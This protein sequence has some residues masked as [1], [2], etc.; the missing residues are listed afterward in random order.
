MHYFIVNMA[1]SDLMISVVHLPWRIS[2]TYRDG[3]WLVDGI[4]GTVLSKLVFFAWPV[5]DGVSIVSMIVIAVERF[6]AILFPMKSA[7]LSRNKH[8]LI[9]ATTWIISVAL[10]GHFFMQ[11]RQLF[12]IMDCI[13]PSNGSQHRTR[14][15]RP[16]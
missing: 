5:S 6:R 10:W 11:P 3:L 8:R 7:S 13:V 12:V 15:T 14:G 4:T 16:E 2:K 9:I 1:I